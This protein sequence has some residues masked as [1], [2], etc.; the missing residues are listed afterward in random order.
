MKK[1]VVF[2]V[3]ALTLFCF[4]LVDI[5]WWIEIS[6]D[7]SKSLEQVKSQ[8]NEKF[9]SFIGKGHGVAL[10]N[11]LFLAIAGLLFFKSKSLNNLKILS[12]IFLGCCL[13][14]GA[15]QIFSLL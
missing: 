3:I 6:S 7:Y 5:Y 13:I 4:V 2:F 15:W 1:E 14:I 12:Q 9:P 11:I 10:M 8:Y